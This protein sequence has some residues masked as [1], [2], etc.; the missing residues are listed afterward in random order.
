MCNCQS[1]L[2]ALVLEKVNADKR[3]KK[4]AIKVTMQ[5]ISYVMGGGTVTTQTNTQF[6][7][8]LEGQKKKPHVP[9]MHSY[10]AFCGEA[11]VSQ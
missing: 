11:R 5:G 10:C 2:E 9:I 4:P 1:E 3:Y 8:E 7:V 6:E